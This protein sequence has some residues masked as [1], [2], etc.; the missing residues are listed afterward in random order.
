MHIH[1]RL[2][3]GVDHGIHLF[4]GCFFLHRDNHC[5]FPCLWRRPGV[6][7]DTS[8]SLG[9]LCARCVAWLPALCLC[10]L[11]A[12][13]AGQLV[14]LQCPHHVDNAFINM[15]QLDVRQRTFVGRAHIGVDNLLAIRLV[16]RQRGGSLQIADHLRRARPFAQQFNELAVQ[17][18]DSDS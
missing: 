16:D 17:H 13:L 7:S 12:S 15:R 4:F 1:A 10:C 5:F 11:R 18:I 2:F 8:K 6:P 14:P 3:H 9:W